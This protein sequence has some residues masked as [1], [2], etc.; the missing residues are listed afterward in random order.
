M[1]RKTKILTL[2]VA[3]LIA[4]TAGAFAQGHYPYG[5]PDARYYGGPRYETVQP[6][7]M[8]QPAQPGRY[9]AM[10]GSN[11]PAPSS[12]QGDVGPE[13]NNNGTLTGVYRQW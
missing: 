13:G 1:Q 2:A 9:G 8:Y 11:H 4:T 5:N 12:T 6:H 10:N 3:S 7:V